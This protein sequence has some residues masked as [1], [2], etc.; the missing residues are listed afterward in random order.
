MVEPAQH[1]FHKAQRLEVAGPSPLLGKVNESDHDPVEIDR[2]GFEVLDDE[3]CMRLLATATLGRIALTSGALPTVLPVSFAVDGDR[4]VIRTGRGSKLDGA[5]RNAVV[6]F[7][8]DDF[9]PTWGSG[10]SVVVTGVAREVTHPDEVARLSS[11]L[12]RRWP[13]LGGE[14]LVTIPVGLISGRRLLT[15]SRTKAG[16]R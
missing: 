9:E 15:A 6:A 10:W 1:G 3:E 12:G 11:L 5:T 2:D 7:E 14:R 16:S 13:A 4:I 8:V